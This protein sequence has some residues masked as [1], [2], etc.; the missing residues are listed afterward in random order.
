MVLPPCTTV[1]PG[2]DHYDC[3]GNGSSLCT[4][5]STASQNVGKQCTCSQCLTPTTPVPPPSCASICPDTTNMLCNRLGQCSCGGV[6]CVAPF[7]TSTSAPASLPYCGDICPGQNALCTRAGACTCNGIA[8]QPGSSMPSATVAT[9]APPAGPT[10]KISP[11]PLT[12]RFPTS[13]STSPAPTVQTR[14]RAVSR[15]ARLHRSVLAG[16]R[17]HLRSASCDS[18]LSRS[19]VSIDDP[20]RIARS[21]DDRHDADYHDTADSG[22]DNGAQHRGEDRARNRWARGPRLRGFTARATAVSWHL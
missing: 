2:V 8:C 3:V 19:V 14:A 7:P 17:V 16:R 11:S 21:Y 20:G 22:A 6:T 4:C 10:I 13:T 5:P 12:S 1:C 15:A 9:T 18:S